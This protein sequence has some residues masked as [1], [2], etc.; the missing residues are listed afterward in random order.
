[1]KGSPVVLL[2]VIGGLVVA[3]EGSGGE[4]ASECRDGQADQR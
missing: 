3:D 2:Q 4:H 1:M